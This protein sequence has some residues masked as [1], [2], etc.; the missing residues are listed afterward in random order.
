MN[1]ILV[2]CE[3]AGKT[4]LAAEIAEWS[5]STLGG[6]GQFHDHFTIPCSELTGQ[7]AQDY[8]TAH[9]QV[10][11]MFQ[12]FM[13]AY[14]VSNI[15]YRNPDHN[16]V[17]LHIEEAVY[18][19][20][21]YGYGGKNSGA[22][23]RSPDGQRTTLARDMEHEILER[24]PETVL[25]LMKASPE[26]IKRRMRAHLRD[27]KTAEAQHESKPSD[28]STRGVVREQDVEFV[29]KRF[30]EEFEASLLRNKI[31]LDTTTSMLEE[32]LEEFVGKVQRYLTE[33]DRRRMRDRRSG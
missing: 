4:T 15:F 17:G 26:V 33:A 16:V 19:P 18:A 32:T 23:S 1:I 24:A 29:L 11:E 5:L 6:S 13:I 7:A 3:F 21:Y 20:L 22:L 9:P 27:S 14:H 2:G 8:R 12:R 10:K 28:E 30:E 25:V 31:V